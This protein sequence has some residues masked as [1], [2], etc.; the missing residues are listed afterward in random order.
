MVE[1][2]FI[3]AKDLPTL[4]NL[5]QKS[6]QVYS[7]DMRCKRVNSGKE[8]CWSQTIVELE[9]MDAAEIHARRLNAKS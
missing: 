1:Y 9:Q 6:F 2:H 7:L 8:T 4:H 5:V 3:S